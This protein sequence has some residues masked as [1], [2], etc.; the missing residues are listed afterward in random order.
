MVES[1]D[2]RSSIIVLAAGSS[3][4]MGRPKPL[5]PFNGQTCL[6]LVLDA[7]LRS[8]AEE[9][10]LVLGAE[11]PSIL[12]EAGRRVQAAQGNRIK[13]IINEGYA[14]GQTSTLKTGLDSM[15]GQ[16]DAFFLFPVDHPLVTSAEIDKLID[17]LEAKPRGRTIFIP[18][19]ESRRGHPVLFSAAHRAPILE[20]G[21]DEPV[22][23]YVRLREGEIEQVSVE[24]PGVVS[25]MNTP[26][27]YD[28]VLAIYKARQRRE[29]GVLA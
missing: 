23:N 11:A 26:E 8:R 14:R 27:E 19:H 10:V 1:P 29:G 22:H 4:R 3:Q 6:S 9:T 15:S 5:L 24:N 21:D 13:Y 28:K 7:A 12:T 16:S 25:E 2:M 18:A 20:L 17:R